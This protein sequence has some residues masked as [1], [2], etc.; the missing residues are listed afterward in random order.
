MK[1]DVIVIGGGPAGM[2]AAG[3]A[4]ETDAKVLLVEKNNRLGIKLLI[5]GNGRCNITNQVSN[6]REF[7][8]RFD[9]GSFLFSS[10]NKF[11]VDEVIDFF[12]NR[13]VATKVEKENQVFPIT[14]RSQDVLKA[15]VDYMKEGGV[16]VKTDAEVKE[17]RVVGKRI[18][19]IILKDGKKITA[20]NYI[21]ATGGKS[22]PATGST[23]EAYGWL[24][25]I[26]HTI[27]TPVP[28]YT[29]VVVKEKFIK[30]LEG[31]SLTDVVVNLFDGKRKID[32]KRGG[33]LFT[34]NG[35]SGPAVLA[36]SKKI[37]QELV[38]QK[39]LDLKLDFY[40]DLDFALLDKKVQATFQAD[41]NRVLKNC[42]EKLL[43]QRFIPVALFVAGI[44]SEK[45]VNLVTGEERRRLIHKL[46]EFNL[47]IDGTVGFNKA[48]VTA[49]GVALS[50]IDPKTMK[51][52]LIDNLYLAG[53]IL[54]LDG[55]TGG[56]NLQVCWSTGYTAGESIGL[57]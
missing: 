35:L 44:D 36:L 31:L 14:D 48:V 25:R 51:S 55:P 6:P 1:Y 7:I 9:N 27:I 26:G 57:K 34:F 41:N 33:A 22:Y 50:E 32:S 29:P 30:E 45:K 19:N 46:K 43:P 11:G 3:R 24:T 18:E 28:A 53:E 40:P 8:S 17:L 39:K 16:E 23:G 12:N 20:E 2:M 49:G 21:I 4:G 52:K 5:S 38:S 15:L 54:D 13:G 10:M 42:L 37:N 56:F 47:V